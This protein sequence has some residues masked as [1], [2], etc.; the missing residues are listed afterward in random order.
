MTMTTKTAGMIECDKQ[1]SGLLVAGEFRAVSQLHVEELGRGGGG[2][3]GQPG[4]EA[5][6]VRCA[7]AVGAR[8]A[9][10]AEVL[11]AQEGQRVQLGAAEEALAGRHF[12]RKKY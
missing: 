11:R 8:M 9:S 10:R 2:V 7:R 3:R 4:D 5:G 6:S 1:L 12:N